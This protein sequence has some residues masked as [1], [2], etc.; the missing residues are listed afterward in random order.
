MLKS[1]TKKIVICL[2]SIMMVILVGTK[3]LATSNSGSDILNNLPKSNNNPTTNLNENEEAIPEGTRNTPKLNTNNNVENNTDNKLE[4]AN[5][6]KP[7]TN[8]D[9]GVEDYSLFVFITIFAVSA[10]Y[11]YKKIKEYRI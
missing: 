3:T 2:I 11:A 6:N 7:T 1:N 9:T 10:I 8:P 4:N 5:A